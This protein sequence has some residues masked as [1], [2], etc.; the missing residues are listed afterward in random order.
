MAVDSLSGEQQRPSLRLDDQRLMAWRVAGVAKIR[1]PGAGSWSP[2]TCSIRRGG[3]VDP[4]EDRVVV[5]CVRD[6]HS[7]GWT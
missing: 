4:L 6:A 2:A 3:K 5:R 1:M 7:A